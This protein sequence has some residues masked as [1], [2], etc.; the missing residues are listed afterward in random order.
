MARGVRRGGDAGGGGR[1]AGAGV[2]MFDDGGPRPNGASP[3]LSGGTHWVV[4]P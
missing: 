4:S 2:V 3:F 1:G